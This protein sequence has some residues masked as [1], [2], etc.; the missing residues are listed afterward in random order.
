M[1]LPLKSVAVLLI[2]AWIPGLFFPMGPQHLSAQ[3]PSNSP[4]D[5][6]VPLFNGKNLEGWVPVNTHEGTFYVKD[7]MI[8]T[9]GKP[10]GFM[11]TEKQY[12]NFILELEWKHTNTK[13]VG[14]SGLFLWADPLPALGTPFTRGIEVQVLVNLE[15]EG[16][17]TSHGDIFSIWGATCVPDRPHP[18]GWPRCLPS[19]R[20]AKGGGE[21]NHYRVEAKNGSIKLAV[22]GKE[23]SGVSKASP[24]KGYIAL[25]AEGAECT[26]RNLRIKELPGEA[27]DEKEA[28]PLAQG[29]QF[30]LAHDGLRGFVT[31][32]GTPWAMQDWMLVYRGKK[33]T[34]SSEIWSTK[35]YGNSEFVAEWRF[36]AEKETQGNRKV[37]LGLRGSNKALVQLTDAKTG[38]GGLPLV[39][40]DTSLPE[41]V[42][43]SAEPR[44]I[45][46]AKPGEWNRL[47]GSLL[48][49]QLNLK[50]NGKE[51]IKAL[52]IEGILPEG[53]LGLI[54]SSGTVDFA[55]LFVR[56]LK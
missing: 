31:K 35:S 19:E 7:S 37:Y 2:W 27:I 36:P 46:D 30:L 33:G 9:T 47:E 1:H 50:I 18:L 20:R 54:A 45:A 23:V 22:N 12:Q 44:E 56:E 52:T 39:A 40:G 48:G 25:E 29:H 10:T 13:D 26:F 3:A 11:R 17:Y 24:S 41:A 28:T 51:V 42:R 55:N 43:T 21:W 5:G 16:Q 32:P 15:K 49:N 6:F 53:P 38:S 8:V 4:T 14:N 34:G